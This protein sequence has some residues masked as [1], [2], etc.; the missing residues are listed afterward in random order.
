MPANQTVDPEDIAELI[1]RCKLATSVSEFHGSLVGYISAGGRFS[2]GSVLDALQIEPDPAPSADEQAMLARLRHQT[3]AWLADTDLTF[4]PWLPEEDAPLAER[5]EGLTEW[6]R[7][8]LGG[9][10]LGGTAE[11]AKALSEDAR[12]VLKD[13]ATIAAT[14]FVLDEDVEGDEESLTEI[15]EFVRVGA[16]LLHAEAGGRNEPASDTLH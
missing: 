11:T 13:M 1:G 16:L 9:F 4:G 12:E 7:G 5:A 2:H 15:E 3:E 14:E 8:F 6:T 10:G